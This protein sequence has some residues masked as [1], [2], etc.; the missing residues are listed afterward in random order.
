MDLQSSLKPGPLR[1]APIT[2]TTAIMNSSKNL[3][4]PIT[5]QEKAGLYKTCCGN[6]I[7]PE[8]QLN[9]QLFLILRIHLYSPPP[10]DFH[11]F[12]KPLRKPDIQSCPGLSYPAFCIK[13]PQSLLSGNLRHFP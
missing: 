6:F 5:K 9:N 3:F 7:N 11:K 12:Y 2:T 1:Q 8:S 10:S 4:I 13:P